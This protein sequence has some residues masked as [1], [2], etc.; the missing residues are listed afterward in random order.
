LLWQFLPGFSSQPVYLAIYAG[1]IFISR[2]LMEISIIFAPG[3][4]RPLFL[5]VARMHEILNILI[6]LSV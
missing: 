5:A 6:L 4:L 3:N 1:G 2:V